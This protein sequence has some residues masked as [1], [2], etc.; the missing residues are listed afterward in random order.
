M[1]SNL[2]FQG[3][4][5]L[6]F[7]IDTKSELEAVRLL[8][9]FFGERA[10]TNFKIAHFNRYGELL[11]VKYRF[12]KE[13]LSDI[14]YRAIG[15][16]KK[17]LIISDQLSVIRA[18]KLLKICLPVEVLLKKLL[19]YVYPEI[20]KVLD[21]KMDKATRIK[22]CKQINSLYFG[23]LLDI[24]EYDMSVKKREELI[25]D[26]GKILSRIFE[27]SANF[28]EFKEKMS[29]YTKP[30]IVWDQ[31]NSVLEKPVTYTKIQKELNSLRYL[32]NKAA[33][34]QVILEKDLKDAKNNSHFILKTIGV[35]K[36]DYEK[37]LMKAMANLSKTIGGV[38]NMFTIDLSGIIPKNAID[39]TPNFMKALSNLE[40][41][42]TKSELISLVD[43]TD[44]STI[45]SEIFKISP[46]ISKIINRF[47]YASMDD[48]IN[49]MNKELKEE[50]NGKTSNEN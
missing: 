4:Y 11:F 17:V 27:E 18:G 37:S 47:N 12:K 26:N 42:N 21:G 1:P 40:S 48:V 5:E 2:S 41:V 24:L 7:A 49:H 14:V 10:K 16:C 15:Q 13:D 3:G 39:I 45:N 30:N 29:K 9:K 34:P 19:T 23:K 32:R 35:V 25:F 43:K 44:W 31:I 33:H 36:N 38:A 6:E 20:I 50:I 8:S 22:I 28:V 46:D